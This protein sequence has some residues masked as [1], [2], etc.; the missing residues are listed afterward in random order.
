MGFEGPS[1][2]FLY[3][4]ILD[5]SNTQNLH[6]LYVIVVSQIKNNVHFYIASFK[7]SYDLK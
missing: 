2:T 6:R 1:L 4:P 7:N 5:S 3:T